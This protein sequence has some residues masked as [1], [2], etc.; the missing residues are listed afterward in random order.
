MK[1][2]K[3]KDIAVQLRTIKSLRIFF[4]Y[5][6]V[7]LLIVAVN[8]L[9]TIIFLSISKL[10]QFWNLIFDFEFFLNDSSLKT[11]QFQSKKIGKHDKPLQKSSTVV[12][13]HC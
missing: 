9:E 5:V 10:M 11:K 4:C 1:F 12:K 6:S 7:A 2:P 3:C 8:G 13:K